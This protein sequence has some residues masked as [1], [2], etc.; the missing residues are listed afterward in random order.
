MYADT[1]LAGMPPKSYI[2]NNA[3][4]IN[5]AIYADFPPDVDPF[6]AAQKAQWE[7]EPRKG[8]VRDQQY[9]IMKAYASAPISDAELRRL[10]VAFNIPLSQVE[11]YT[12]ERRKKIA[13]KWEPTDHLKAAAI[14]FGVVLTAGAIGTALG[15]GG[16]ATS[17]AGGTAS[18]AAGTAAGSAAGSLSTVAPAL[19]TPVITAPPLALAPIAPIG[20]A[21]S[22]AGAA[23]V[24]GS[25]ATLPAITVTASQGITA[26]QVI[27]AAGAVGA[28]L[29][30]PGASQAASAAQA[31]Q[32]GSLNQWA[33]DEA[34]RAAVDYGTG[35]AVEKYAESQAKKLTAAQ[36]AA[37]RAEL[38]KA[39]QEYAR[40]QMRATP[41]AETAKAAPEKFSINPLWYVAAIA[42]IL[43]LRN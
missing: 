12:R 30:V 21:G 39:Q 32:D 33:L 19:A 3:R 13:N 27:K 29:G 36:E 37:L 23:V 7:K 14:G 20:A 34:K 41:P 2:D 5:A 9:K 1:T 28:A 26:A 18:G 22:A 24:G 8:G 35:Y 17:A 31:Y 40:L 25:V 42:A 43:S 6:T 38:E 10:S 4:K 16:A 15:A 11:A